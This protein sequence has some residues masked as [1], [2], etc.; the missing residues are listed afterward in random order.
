MMNSTDNAESHHQTFMRLIE[1]EYAFRP[2][3]RGDIVEAVIVA[4]DAND[5][6]VDLGAKR[7]GIVPASDLRRVDRAYLDR[8]RVG[9]SIP[10]VVTHTEADQT[11]ILVSLSS[12]LQQEDWLRAKEMLE[13]GKTIACPVVA[14]NMGGIVVQ[15]GRLQG[16]VPNSHLT[17]QPMRTSP[18]HLEETKAQLVGQTLTLAILDVD[19]RRRRLVLSKRAADHQRR[20]GLLADIVPGQRRT[21]VVRNLVEF[22]AFVDLGGIDGL[23]HISELDWQHVKHPADVLQ[24]GQEVHVEVLN[25]DLERERIGLSRK[26]ALPDP[27]DE[28]LQKIKPGDVVAGVVSNIVDLGLFV[29]LGRGVE[30]LLRRSELPEWARE[31]DAPNRGATI[32]VRIVGI[33]EERRRISLQLDESAWLGGDPDQQAERAE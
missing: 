17:W 21:G 24:V 12:G 27:W 13:T 20:E 28:T 4:I 31:F 32:H 7:D 14:V 25:V 3:R 16:F 9:Q 1:N 5:I 33:D 19:Q 10:I 11:G 18:S 30:G 6:L 2:P 15:F 8:L 22:G 26:R 23:I 29:E